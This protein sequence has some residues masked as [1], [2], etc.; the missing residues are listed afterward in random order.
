M[1]LWTRGRWLWTRTIGSMVL[2]EGVD[3]LLFYPLAFWHAPGFTDA[4][5][6]RVALTQWGLK[7][8]WEVLLTPVTYRVVGWLKRAEGVDVFDEGTDFSPF[9]RGR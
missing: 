4:L 8:G 7:V 3:S 2:G 9:G 1:K 6:I 5:V